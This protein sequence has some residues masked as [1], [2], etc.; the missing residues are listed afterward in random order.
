MIHL[1]V[2]YLKNIAPTVTQQ[3][4][5]VLFNQFVLDNGGP[6]DVRLMTGRM[7]GQAFVR[8]QSKL[9]SLIYV[10]IQTKYFCLYLGQLVLFILTL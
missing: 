7:R 8:F 9:I 10:K 2:L 6:I 3:Q 5:S 4:L 1:Q